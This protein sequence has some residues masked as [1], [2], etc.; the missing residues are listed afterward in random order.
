MKKPQRINLASFKAE[1]WPVAIRPARRRKSSKPDRVLH[2]E[3]A[4]AFAASGIAK[5]VTAGEARA[6]VL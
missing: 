6:S 3:V 2:L 5:S 4:L 1:S